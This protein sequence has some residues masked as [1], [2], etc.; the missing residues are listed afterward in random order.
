MASLGE[1]ILRAK[2]LINVE[3]DTADIVMMFNECSEAIADVAGY[4][5]MAEANY[6]SSQPIVTLP[7]DLVDIAELK[8]KP[9]GKHFTRMLSVGVVQPHDSYEDSPLS[10]YGPFYYEWF[11][12]T[13]EIRPQPASDGLLQIRYYA[14]LPKFLPPTEFDGGEE[15]PAF[16]AQ[17]PTLHARY[18]RIYPLYAAARHAQHWKDSEQEKADLYNDYLEVRND[19]EQDTQKVKI[20]ARSKTVYRTHDFI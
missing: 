9:N 18:H 16:L 4:A 2:Y 12:N 10:D 8:I 11:G 15:D 1:L 3:V 20:R 19:L 13:V 14:T 7:I 6:I 5:K 17:I